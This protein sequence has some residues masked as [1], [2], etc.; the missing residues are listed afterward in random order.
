MEGDVGCDEEVADFEEKLQ[1]LVMELHSGLKNDVYDSEEVNVIGLA[2]DRF[3][4][5]PR[6]R[7]H[8]CW[9]MKRAKVET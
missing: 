8:V 2:I 9:G 6:V 3:Q 7:F 1:S 4:P 5:R